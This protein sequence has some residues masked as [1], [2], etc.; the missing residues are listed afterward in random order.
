MKTLKFNDLEFSSDENENIS[1]ISRWMTGDYQKHEL[2][3]R[4]TFEERKKLILFLVDPINNST[5]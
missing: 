5:N 3:Y 4:L 2:T 1:V